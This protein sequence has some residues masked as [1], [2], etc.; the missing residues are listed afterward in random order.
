M[1]RTLGRHLLTLAVAL[2]L[3]SAGWGVGLARAQST[4][5][6]WT[7]YPP[8]TPSYA[9][10]IRPPIQSNGSSVFSVGS[11]IPVKFKLLSGPGVFLF[12]SVW[13]NNFGEG[14][15]GE[16]SD[17]FAVLSFTPSGSLTFAD[18][19][20]L[21]A[22]YA[23]T[24]GNCQGGSLRWSVTFDIGNDDGIPPGESEPDP[25]DNDR[26]IFIYYGG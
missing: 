10:V 5:G 12:D 6:T 4:S 2:A 22:N 16:H 13:S 26:S 19:T 8:Q 18:I 3:G 11:T 24:L 20:N 23:F 25:R 7:H 17:D 15:D 21:T 9:S 14:G 1:T